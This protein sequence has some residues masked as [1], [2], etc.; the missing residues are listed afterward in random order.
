MQPLVSGS[1]TS[2]FQ[3]QFSN[4]PT[5]MTSF[6]GRIQITPLCISN[7]SVRTVQ[8]E[9]V[10]LAVLLELR[11]GLPLFGFGLA[12]MMNTNA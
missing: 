9:S 10:L 4:S 11:M 5:R 8:C 3:W 12:T 6:L 7:K 1:A 2:D